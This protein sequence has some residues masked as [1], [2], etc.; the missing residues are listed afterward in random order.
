LQQAA[1]AARTFCAE[2]TPQS[3]DDLPRE[4]QEMLVDF[5]YAEPTD[6]VR[7]E[8]IDAVLSGDWKRLIDEC[9]YVRY[10]GPSPDQP[11]NKA[12]ADRWIYSEKLI[13]LRKTP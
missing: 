4:K 12:F 5:F 10:Y 2:R 9:L 8:L 7:I 6:E 11:R 3:F 1:A 13:P